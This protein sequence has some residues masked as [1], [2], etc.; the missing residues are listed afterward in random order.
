MFDDQYSQPARKPWRSPNASLTHTYSPPSFGIAE[1]SVITH[2]P[3][4]MKNA[5]AASTHNTS[6]D[7]PLCAV[8]ATQR[9]PTIAATLNS[10]RSKV[11]RVLARA[12]DELPQTRAGARGAA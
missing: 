1:D 12:T 5:T 2:R 11:R 7:G 4:G 3:C 10:T 9:R 6:D 8:S